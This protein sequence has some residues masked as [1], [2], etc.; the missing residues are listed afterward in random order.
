[1]SS[2]RRTGE[3]TPE[4]DTYFTPLPEEETLEI[5][6]SISVDESIESL[7]DPSLI[8]KPFRFIR[9]TAISLF[10]LLLVL[11]IWQSIELLLMLTDVHWVLGAAFAGLLVILAGIAG[12][13][14]LDF[15]LYRR[16][17]REIETLRRS[18]TEMTDVRSSGQGKHWLATL[19]AL[20]KG[21]PQEI[22]LNQALETLPDYSDDTET[23][24]HINHHFLSRLD[25]QALSRISTHSQQAALMVA[26]SPVA[27][28]DMLL[29]CWRA[30]RMIDE[31][32]QIYGLRPSLPVRG[33]LLKMVM[34]QVAMA[35][36]TELMTGQL[37]DFASNKLVGMVSSQAASG[38]GVGLY[39][40]RVGIHA[41]ALVRPVPFP[42]D[43]K[44][45]LRH[46]ANEVKNA[47][48]KQFRRS[49]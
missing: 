10:S 33:Q 39:S 15:F 41:M 48:L 30:M 19:Q 47:I 28:I 2:Q 37:A 45:G 3:Q 7:T 31:I 35:G 24:Q 34:E 44:P 1:L 13:S 16:D 11:V 27:I 42:S 25:Q 49:H 46:V 8:L 29:A 21:K 9:R 22:M 26:L 6:E 20:Y 5:P 32:C 38:L 40:A 14:C 43:E 18:A 4:K 23:V 12:K 17:F 36:A